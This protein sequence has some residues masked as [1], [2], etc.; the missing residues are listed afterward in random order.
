MSNRNTILIVVLLVVS[1]AG[2]FYYLYERMQPMYEW[3]DS[4]WTKKSYAETSEEPYGTQIFHR[5]LGRYF[6]GHTLV[7]LKAN[8]GNELPSDSSGHYNYV[9]V[10]EALYLDSL[11]TRA[12]L[13]F[14]ARG[15]TALLASKTIPFDLMN[16]IYYEECEDAIWNDY[17]GMEDTVVQLSL[18]E[19]EPRGPTP[20]HYARQNRP[21]AYTWR[22]I[23]RDFFCEGLPQRPIGYLN[24]SLVNF[25]DFPH[26]GGHFLLH[27]NPVAFSN[28]SLL[29]PEARTYAEGVLSW[30]SPGDIYWDAV[31]RVPEAVGRKRNRSNA[32]GESPSEKSPL[33]YILQQPSLAWAW[34]LLVGLAGVWLLFRSKRRQR[35]IPVLPKNENSS[36]EFINTISNLHFRDRNYQGLCA[37]SMKL[38]LAHVRERYGVVAPINP[39]TGLPKVDDAFFQRLSA[40]SEVPESRIRDI[41]T[42]Y[43]HTVDY[44]PTEEMMVNLH[45]LMEAFFEK[46]K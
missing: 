16:Y 36:F 15:N 30:L 45:L 43:A 12:L 3:D 10:G 32:G 37:Q 40:G 29:R 14:V 1:L 11:S 5:L 33:A 22:H 8:V 44:Q 34:Y 24:D 17:A 13:D 7:N 39:E 6:E 27:T 28:Y 21:A 9:F 31:S 2:L 42:Q 38:F 35:I 18:A 41:F 23:G 19:P 46:A 20:F 4:S 26:G 25:A